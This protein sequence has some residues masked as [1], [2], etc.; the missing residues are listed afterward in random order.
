MAAEFSVNIG[1][2][3]QWAPIPG[4]HFDVVVRNIPTGGDMTPPGV[5][6]VGATNSVT[7]FALLDGQPLGNYFILVRSKYP[8]GSGASDWSTA[9]EF[10]L[11][12]FPVPTGITKV[13]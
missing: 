4:A 10:S 7:V 1:D 12:G 8:D 2:S 13:P 11:V 9:V 6:D 3:I 5:L